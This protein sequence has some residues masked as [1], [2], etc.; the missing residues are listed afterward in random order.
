[1]TTTLGRICLESLSLTSAGKLFRARRTLQIWHQ[2][3]TIYSAFMQ[4][5][6]VGQHFRNAAE[7]LKRCN[8][9]FLRRNTKLDRKSRTMEEIIST[10]Y[11]Q[12][13][14]SWKKER[15]KLS[16][17]LINE[18]CTCAITV[19]PKIT[20]TSELRFYRVFWLRTYKLPAA[21]CISKKQTV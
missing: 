8:V 15:L 9:I 13:I 4:C 21:K 6:L 12:I 17:H 14:E 7:I 5:S 3:I 11:A 2:Q 20:T 1:M 10:Y 16:V 19:L 18:T